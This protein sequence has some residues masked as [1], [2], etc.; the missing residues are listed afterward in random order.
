MDFEFVD[1]EL[2]MLIMQ[3]NDIERMVT[4]HK[5]QKKIPIERF[6]LFLEAIDDVRTQIAGHVGRMGGEKI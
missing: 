4:Y 6:N 1:N 5:E 3:L 2:L